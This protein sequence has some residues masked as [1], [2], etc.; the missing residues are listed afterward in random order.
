MNGAPVV[1]L[2]KL[3]RVFDRRVAVSELD[4]VVRSGEFFAFLGPRIRSR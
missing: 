2:S 3:T 4:L 1:E